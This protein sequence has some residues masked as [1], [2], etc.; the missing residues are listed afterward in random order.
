MR[1]RWTNRTRDYHGPTVTLTVRVRED[2]AKYLRFRLGQPDLRT[3]TD[4][5]QDAIALWRAFEER[6]A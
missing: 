2:D 5:V 3:T 4:A 6:D 1:P